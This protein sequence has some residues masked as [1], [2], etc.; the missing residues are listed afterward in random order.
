MPIG[1]AR[2][3]ADGPGFAPVVVRDE[4]EGLPARKKAVGAQWCHEG[5]LASLSHG[6]CLL[7]KA[8]HEPTHGW[9]VRQRLRAFRG[10][11]C[12][13]AQPA[14]LDVLD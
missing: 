5:W 14:V 7:M 8:R 12:Q 11:Y 9:K 1:R 4:R 2:V 6:H 13:R 10:L 3:F